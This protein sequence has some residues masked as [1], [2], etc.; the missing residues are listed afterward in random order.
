[1]KKQKGQTL[2][3][4]LVALST[5]VIV[6]SAITAV[7]ISALNNAEFEKNQGLSVSYA[8][9][10][11]EIVRSMKNND[12]TT[13]Q[14]LSNKYCLEKSCNSIST[15]IGNACGP[16]VGSC[17]QNVDTFVREVVFEQKS[18]DCSAVATKVTV[19]VSWSDN[20]CSGSNIFCHVTSIATCM[21]DYNV[22]PTP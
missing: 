5:I 3:E 16:E 22:L 2:V 19:N 14:T 1:M 12:Y 8:Q 13:F 7:S 10:G 6:V 4:V 21:S 18:I 9:Q 20:K 11:M 17:S 15:T